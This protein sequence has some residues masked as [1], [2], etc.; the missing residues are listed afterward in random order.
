[1]A[2][3]DV[4]KDLKKLAMSLIEAEDEEDRLRAQLA[5]DRIFFKEINGMTTQIQETITRISKIIKNVDQDTIKKRVMETNL[6]ASRVQIIA[7]EMQCLALKKMEENRE[8]TKRS[9]RMRT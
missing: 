7:E 6:L 1:M 5:R 4:D 9:K 2:A 3:G 8:A